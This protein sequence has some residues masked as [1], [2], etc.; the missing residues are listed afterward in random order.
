M[1]Y[2]GGIIHMDIEYEREELG[3]PIPTAW[4]CT[5]LKRDRS[6]VDRSV[7]VRVD[8]VKKNKPLD[9]EFTPQF[10]TGTEV[11][12]IERRR[13]IARKGRERR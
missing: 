9:V 3:I 4:R 8:S 10:V 11:R 13:Y 12:D 6:S 7:D 5:Q 2:G 1:E